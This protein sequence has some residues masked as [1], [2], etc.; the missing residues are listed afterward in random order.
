MNNYKKG[1]NMTKGV[2]LFIT[3]IIEEIEELIDSEVFFDSRWSSK[4]IYDRKLEPEEDYKYTE[5]NMLYALSMVR[6]LLEETY[7]KA[8]E[9][10]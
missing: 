10:E 5:G 7:K 3:E 1:N 4:G 2:L 9:E 6:K 8:E